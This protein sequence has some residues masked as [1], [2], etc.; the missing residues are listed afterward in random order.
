MQELH[1]QP[2]EIRWPIFCVLCGNRDE[3]SRGCS[4]NRTRAH[5]LVGPCSKYSVYH[6]G[7][8]RIFQPTE[9]LKTYYEAA[10]EVDDRERLN[11]FET[12]TW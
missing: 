11:M 1:E 10:P 8:P 2:K 9:L 6:G 7:C 4:M 5:K 3:V 12:L